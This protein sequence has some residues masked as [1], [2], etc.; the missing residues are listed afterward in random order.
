MTATTLPDGVAVLKAH[1]G[2]S[3]TLVHEGSGR[4]LVPGNPWFAT[5]R[6]AL[7]LFAACLAPLDLDW[8]QAPETV[9]EALRARYSDVQ[10]WERALTIVH[11]P[12]GV[13]ITDG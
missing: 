3:W 7:R 2:K 8:T 11:T 12:E 6:D 9:A 5:K 10:A 13:R 4:A 1:W